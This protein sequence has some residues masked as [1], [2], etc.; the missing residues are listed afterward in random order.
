ML[1]AT[2]PRRDSRECKM[3]LDETGMGWHAVRKTWLRGKHCQA[4]DDVRNLLAFVRG[5]WL[6]ISRGRGG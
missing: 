4:K 5:S 1:W 6:A 3:G 2:Q